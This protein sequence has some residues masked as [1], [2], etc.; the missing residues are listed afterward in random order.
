MAKK[1]PKKGMTLTEGVLI[2][3]K[4]LDN[5]IARRVQRGPE[6]R[7]I[8]GIQKWE[9][10]ADKIEEVTALVLE[11]FGDQVVNLD[12]ILVLSQ[13]FTKSL[14]LLVEDLGEDGLGELR[15]NYSKDAFEKLL[16]DA[17]C[18]VEALD[19]RERVQ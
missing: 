16:R 17:S 19:S 4:A 13:A 9:P 15:T 14:Y 7:E 8:K 5:Q 1:D 3:M 2:A 6:E 10:H 12:S 11:A 18:G